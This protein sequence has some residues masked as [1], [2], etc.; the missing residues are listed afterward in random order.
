[1]ECEYRGLLMSCSLFYKSV[2]SYYLACDII[3]LLVDSYIVSIGKPIFG[4]N[5]DLIVVLASGH[6]YNWLEVA[7]ICFSTFQ[8]ALT[9]V[10]NQLL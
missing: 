3:L 2:L 5:C 8:I 9:S 1:M 6:F 10:N 7:A 4:K